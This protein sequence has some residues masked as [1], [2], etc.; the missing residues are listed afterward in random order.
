MSS[1]IVRLDG[2]VGKNNASNL[3]QING[4]LPS[5]YVITQVDGNRTDDASDSFTA[6]LEARSERIAQRVEAIRAFVTDNADA[7]GNAVNALRETDQLSASEAAQTTAL[8]DDV[9]AGKSLGA[10]AGATAGAAG[11]K[12]IFGA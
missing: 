9:S 10:A 6:R 12:N 7:L 11:A 1:K 8:I 2:E 4:E 3:H 5:T